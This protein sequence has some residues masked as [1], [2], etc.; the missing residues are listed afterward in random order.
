MKWNSCANKVTLQWRHN[1][2]DPVFQNSTYDYT[3]IAVPFSIVKRWRFSDLPITISNAINNVPY[4]SACKVALEFRTRFW[5]HYANPIY[6]S[7]STSTDIP[8]IGSVCYPSYNINGTGPA[9]MLASY[10][11]GGDW[12]ERWAATPE[13]EHVR[14]VLD[15]MIEIHGDVAR[16]QYTG[17]FNRRCWVLDPLESASWASPMV[18]QHELYLP[19]YFKTQNNVRQGPWRQN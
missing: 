12:G 18:G 6:G 8:G 14:Y 17:K 7:C 11:S 15:A 19:E 9:T 16:E 3:V 13:A 4:T 10:V 5:E 2:T 1:Y